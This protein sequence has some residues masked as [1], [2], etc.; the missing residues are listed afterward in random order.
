MQGETLQTN[1]GLKSSIVLLLYTTPI[2]EGSFSFGKM[3]VDSQMICRS[4]CGNTFSEL[5]V[6]KHV[7]MD[8]VLCEKRRPD[9]LGSWYILIYFIGLEVPITFMLLC[10]L[11]FWSI[12]NASLMK[13]L[14]SSCC[15]V[16]WMFSEGPNCKIINQL[17]AILFI[18]CHSVFYFH[19]CR[20]WLSR[21]LMQAFSFRSVIRQEVEL[22]FSLTLALLGVFWLKLLCFLLSSIFALSSCAQS[23]G[24]AE[25]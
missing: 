19:D 10:L 24:L 5:V 23:T 8:D 21:W 4:V 14:F 6:G 3:L 13:C 25:S 11:H 20:S 1:A 9:H 18:S 7:Q 22:F 12:K 16:R 17:L 2:S 15:L